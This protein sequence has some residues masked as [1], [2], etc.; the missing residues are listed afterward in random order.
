MEVRGGPTTGIDTAGIDPAGVDPTG[1]KIDLDS[2]RQ[3]PAVVEQKGRVLIV[4][5]HA[6][7]PAPASAS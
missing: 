6:L 1:V 2:L 5:E 3:V 4:T 7:K